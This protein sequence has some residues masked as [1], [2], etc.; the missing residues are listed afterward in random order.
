MSDRLC[1]R[2]TLRLRSAHITAL[3]GLVAADLYPNRSAVLRSA[4]EELLTR[5]ARLIVENGSEPTRRHLPDRKGTLCGLGEDTE[6]TRLPSD[7]CDHLTMCR[8][9]DPAVDDDQR[10]AGGSTPTSD[11]TEVCTHGHE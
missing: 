3:D 1:G 2:V 4:V 5:E 8:R 6:F 11:P 10:S 7:Q 9:C